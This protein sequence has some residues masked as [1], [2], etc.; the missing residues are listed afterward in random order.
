MKLNQLIPP[1]GY[2]EEVINY[3]NLPM[4]AVPCIPEPK[5]EPPK[6][7]PVVVIEEPVEEPPQVD[8]LADLPPPEDEGPK[9]DM[10]AG[11]GDGGNDV[12]Q[13][14]QLNTL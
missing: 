13:N 3:G 4:F 5:E 14:G 7:E 1:V 10:L 11:L 2:A 12:P 9:I 8:L 6:P